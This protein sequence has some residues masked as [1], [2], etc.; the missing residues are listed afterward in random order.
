MFSH[1]LLRILPIL[2]NICVTGP[3]ARRKCSVK[4]VPCRSNPRCPLKS[5]IVQFGYGGAVR[6]RL[7]MQR[8]IALRLQATNRI[9]EPLSQCLRGC[10]FATPE[11]KLDQPQTVCQG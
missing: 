1:Y 5:L 2:T 9:G 3:S 10:P 6:V 11:P 8:S 4:I 7:A